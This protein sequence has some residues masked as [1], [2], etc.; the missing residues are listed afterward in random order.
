MTTP[1]ATGSEFLAVSISRGPSVTG[2]SDGGF[3][4]TSISFG[5][6]GDS[7]G[8]LGQRYNAD[9]TPAGTEFQ[10]N[11]YT[12]SFQRDPSVTGLSDGGFVVTWESNGQDDSATGVYGQRYNADGTTVGAE[13]QINTYTLSFQYGPSV[14]GLS[15]GGFVVTWESNGQDGDGGGI[16]AQR[17]NADG[18]TAGAE[19]QINTYTP[20]Y[21]A[22]P[23]VTALSDG[24]F[25]VTWVSEEQDGDSGGIYAQRYNTD[26][27]TAGAEF[28]INTYTASFQNDPSVTGLSD[29]GF[30]VTW[31]SWLQDGSFTGV[32]GQRY[33]AD[34]TPAGAEFQ[35]NTYT[36]INQS[37]PSVTALSDGGFVV[38][39]ESSVQDGDGFGIYGQRYNADGTAGGAEFQINTYTPGHQWNSSVTG[40]SDGGF[41]VTWRSDGQDGGSTGVYAQM[42]SYA[43]G[44]FTAG[45]DTVTLYGP[46][47]TVDGLAGDDIITGADYEDGADIING[48]AGDDTLDGMAGND[49]LNGGDGDD[50]LKGSGGNDILNGDADDDLLKGGGGA[51]NINGGSG[52]DTVSYAGSLAVIVN[53]ATGT[54][55]GG[56]A[57]GDTLTSIERLIGSD[58]DDTLIGDGGDNTLN[59][60]SGNDYLLD[61]S[62]GDDILNGGTGND[63]LQGSGGADSYF[64]GTGTDEVRYNNSGAAV[65]VNLS[66]GFASGGDADGD[67]FDSIENLVGSQFDDTL[68]GDGGI[69]RLEGFLGDDT[70]KGGGGADVLWGGLGFD[71][72]S[73]FDSAVGV[74]ARLF[75]TGSGGT[76]E[77]DT[78]IY[79]EGI[80]GSFFNDTLIGGGAS[81]TLNGNDGDDILFDYSANA[82]LIGGLGNDFLQGG[83]GGDAYD[84]GLG[85]DTVSFAN[86]VGAV[87]ANLATGTGSGNDAAGDTYTG[88]ENLIGS[89]NS[90]T[91]IGDGNDNNLNGQ[92]GVDFLMGGLGNDTLTGGGGIDLFQY[93]ATVWGFDIV[94]DFENGTDF[95]DLRG[96]GL[97]FTDFTEVNTGPGMRLDYTDGGGTLS[98]ISLLGISIADID[99]GDFLV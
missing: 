44:D 94:T 92:G 71:T 1:V 38:T 14:T 85:I 72:A 65:N 17:Y 54:G 49:T 46:G 79:I 64:G 40:L 75:S 66:N 98:T 9:G 97:T 68:F 78:M 24:G 28:Q 8:I 99:A 73:Y 2:L 11:T 60:G 93:D 6:D 52:F 18:T 88:V 37:D 47:Q 77:G 10:I 70:L 55:T 76:A 63:Q 3:V 41:V 95:I 25:V 74:D 22:D 90:D 56:G 20:G 51:D 45:N 61:L 50:F 12:T 48:G 16:Y 29:G 62:G 67:T 69:N 39:W 23:S 13:F 7:N 86:A 21:Q 43:D 36:T 83:I 4:V 59:G 30:V 91:F 53:L 31:Q 19:F 81:V 87:T 58:F 15:G 57:Q 26:G 34:G 42:F 27:T 32:Y 89:A 5:Q 35:I 82:T 96:S 80:T 33:N 84:G